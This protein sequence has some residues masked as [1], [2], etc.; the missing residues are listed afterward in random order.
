MSVWPHLDIIWEVEAHPTDGRGT[1]DKNWGGKHWFVT[2]LFLRNSD[3]FLGVGGG[4]H[5]K[6]EARS[7]LSTAAWTEW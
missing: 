5:G 1:L 4:L 2:L 6:W 7:C 3:G